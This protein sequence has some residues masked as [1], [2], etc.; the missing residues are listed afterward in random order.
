MAKKKEIVEY[1]EYVNGFTFYGVLGNDIITFK[2]KG[3]WR[4]LKTKTPMSEIMCK[5]Q[6]EFGG[7]ACFGSLCRTALGGLHRMAD[8]NVTSFLIGIGKKIMNH[9]T[10]SELGKRS[11]ILSANKSLLESLYFN[12]EI[13]FNTVLL[14]KPVVETDREN[15]KAEIFI[16][17]II[18]E[19]DLI[20][21]HRYPF[22]R[23]LASIGCV[24]DVIYNPIIDEYEPVVDHL[25]NAFDKFTGDW[26]SSFSIVPEQTIT[27]QIPEFS[28][29]EL[30][31][32]VTFVLSIAIQFGRYDWY[33][34]PIEKKHAGYGKILKVF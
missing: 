34:D 1:E 30:T 10:V 5:H 7:C 17:E 29:E 33:K 13:P 21:N 23:V 8:I 18:T 25:Q 11:L 19:I 4:D 3:Y 26:Y 14:V 32:N 22:F 27:L 12:H 31:D 15:L 2:T 9:D 24:S 16:P 20:N 6:I 28:I